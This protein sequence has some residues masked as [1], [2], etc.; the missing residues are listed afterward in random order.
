[1]DITVIVSGDLANGYE[2]VRPIV[3]E[4]QY[5]LEERSEY[6]LVTD[7]HFNR[8]GAH[9]EFRLAVAE[10][11]EDMVVYLETADENSLPESPNESL[12]EELSRYLRR[13]ERYEL[14]RSDVKPLP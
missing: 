13:T 1:M 3:L 8:Y 9:E 6:W 11:L 4:A 12:V 2:T 14:F 7:V 5:I 10:C